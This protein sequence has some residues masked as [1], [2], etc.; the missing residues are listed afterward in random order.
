M[1]ALGRHAART[2]TGAGR[3]VYR[4]GC[5]LCGRRLVSGVLCGNSISIRDAR[6]VADSLARARFV[7]AS[8][9]APPPGSS[10]VVILGLDGLDFGL[11]QKML[12]EGKLP[13]LAALKEEGGFVPLGSTL[14]PISPVAWS[15]FQTGT[16]PGKHN[17][18]DFLIPD[19]RNLSTKAQLRRSPSAAPR[20]PARQIP[21]PARQT[22]R[23]N[24]AQKQAV[25]VRAQRLRHL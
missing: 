15:T 20:A 7:S 5:R 9:P 6:I 10:G 4:A 21:N 13:H 24:V 3:R 1:V 14:P 22:R 16:N 19:Q 2:G 17:I 18:F 11:T 25:L 12:D 8:S 23:A